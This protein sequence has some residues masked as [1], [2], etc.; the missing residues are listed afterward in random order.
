M[1]FDYKN[2]TDAFWKKH[3]SEEVL[4]VCRY[5]GTERSGAGQYDKFYQEGTYAC[6]CCGGDYLLFSSETKFNSGTGWPSFYAPLAN[7]VIEQ[8][9]A[10]DAIRGVFG[11]ARIEVLCVRCESH[12]GHVFDDGPE[13][14]GKRYCMNSIA[15]VFIPA[16]ETPKR[17]FD[18]EEEA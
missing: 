18:V 5:K 14:T 8:P 17:T 9:D 13:P 16:D 7:A 12:L 3:L 6:A 2:Q 1:P 10:G 11:Q 15:L 4:Q